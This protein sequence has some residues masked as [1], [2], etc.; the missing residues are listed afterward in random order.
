MRPLPIIPVTANVRVEHYREPTT[1]R[2]VA[3]QIFVDRNAGR[4]RNRKGRRIDFVW[5]HL[6]FTRRHFS[7]G[8]VWRVVR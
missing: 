5:V 2:S 3:R 7:D 8:L 4:G 1:H 6:M